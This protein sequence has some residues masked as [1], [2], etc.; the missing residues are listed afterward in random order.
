M[1]LPCL[2]TSSVGTEY[3]CV[4]K[5]TVCARAMCE[6]AMCMIRMCAGGLNCCAY[7][8]AHRMYISLY[9]RACTRCVS[10]DSLASISGC[11]TGAQGRQDGWLTRKLG[12]KVRLRSLRHTRPLSPLIVIILCYYNE[13]AT[14][15]SDADEGINVDDGYVCPLHTNSLYRPTCSCGGSTVRPVSR[16]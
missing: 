2:N 16:R 4:R 1:I 9:D 3:Y 8:R 5:H 6:R 13:C 14:V 10:H 12:G 11:R 15:L 7:C